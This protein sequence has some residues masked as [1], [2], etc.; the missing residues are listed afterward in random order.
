MAYV[1]GEEGEVVYVTCSVF[2]WVQLPEIKAILDYLFFYLALFLCDWHRDKQRM[3]R[4]GFAKPG[5][6]FKIVMGVLSSVH[7]PSC[8]K[9]TS[10]ARSRI[11]LD[12]H[13]LG[14]RLQSFGA[15]WIAF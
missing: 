15:A 14:G 13:G 5:F 9:S 2:F 7:T 3:K 8:A 11:S 10:M 12:T 1:Q 4:P 6:F